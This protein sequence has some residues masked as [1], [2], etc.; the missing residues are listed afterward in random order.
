M[1]G[2]SRISGGVDMSWLADM[3]LS[4]SPEQA[5]LRRAVR[6][7]LDRERTERP[8]IFTGDGFDRAF[9]RGLGAQGW[10]GMVIPEK[11]GGVGLGPV[12]QFVVSEELLAARAPVGA[13]IAAERQT[14]PMLIRFG[15]PAQREEFLPLIASGDIG[16]ALGM[17]EPDSGSDLSSVR[18]RA[19]Q[20]DGGW[21]LSGTKV[22]TSWAD[23]V[24]YAVVLCRTAPLGSDKHAG[25]SQLI[26]DLHAPGVTVSPITTIDGRAHFSEVNFS[27]V[28]VRSQRVLGEVGH[29]WRQVTSELAYERSGPDRWLSTFRVYAA[30][31]RA[32][33]EIEDEAVVAIG[34]GAARYRILHELSYGI[35]RAVQDGADPAAAAA[36]VKDL[37]TRFEQEVVEMARQ[38]VRVP[39]PDDRTSGRLSD[40]AAAV[41]DVVL[42]A[43]GFTIR[44]GTTQ[45]LRTVIARELIR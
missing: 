26:V 41:A 38:F 34:R 19:H 3:P 15:T 2:A 31:V 35:A 23:R 39:L 20:V 11:Y 27:D 16:F 22:W 44:G 9:S 32:C 8:E 37:G 18:S 10:L 12:D 21:S 28:F 25:L 7:F 40:L 5:G 14:A 30:L 33:G 43:P 24:E 13:H 6:L 36:V 4:S 17:S 42:V 29:G 1:S 45:I